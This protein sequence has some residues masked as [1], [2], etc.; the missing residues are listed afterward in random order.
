MRETAEAPGTAAAAGSGAAETGAEPGE[1]LEEQQLEQQREREGNPASPE[2][3]PGENKPPTAMKSVSRLPVPSTI[4]N[5]RMHSNENMPMM[6]KRLRISSPEPQQYRVPAS[7]ACTRPKPPAVSAVPKSYLTGRRSLAPVRTNSKAPAMV[8][9]ARQKPTQ[10][11][12]AAAKTE[13]SSTTSGTKKARAAWDLKGKVDDMRDQVSTYKSKLH[14]LAGENLHLRQTLEEIQGQLDVLKVENRELT[15]KCSSFNSELQVTQQKLTQMSEEA[16]ALR[17]VVSSQEGQL[18]SNLS[19][20]AELHDAK[21]HLVELA[22]SREVQ[23][24]LAHNELIVKRELVQSLQANVALLQDVGASKDERLHCLEMERRRLHNIIQELKGNIRVFCRVRPLLK[25]EINCNMDHIQFPP[26]DDRSVI[27]SK[28][29]ESHTG[30]EK[31]EAHKYDFTFDRVFSPSSCQG[32]VFHEISLLV[33]S[34]LDGYHVC[35]FAYGQTGS[36][37]TYTM[38]GPDDVDYETMGMIP[39]AVRQIFQ[40]ADE[41][42]SKGWNYTFTANFL[43]IY[44]E[45]IRD[46]L[47]SKPEKNVEYDIKRVSPSSDELQVTNLRYVGVSSEEEVHKLLRTAKLNRSVAKTVLNDRSS[48]SHSVFQLRIEGRNETRDVK[49]S[50]ILSL[51][52]L[53]GSERLDKSLSKG[54]RLRETQAINTSLSNLGLVITSLSN[55]DSHI[56]FR[57]SK[58]TY[59]LQNSLGGNSKVLMFVNVSP[60]DDNFSESVNSLR[61]ASKVNECVIGTAQANRKLRDAA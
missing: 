21:S 51:I 10:T 59:L 57:N 42:R 44:N 36:G 46:L 43:E 5:K 17:M 39:R 56:P 40:S 50:S 25:A 19:T 11:T 18:S 15:T 27:L 20:I 23:L 9:S 34:A 30:R 13:A 8:S 58:L 48:R 37:K 26:Q 16:A 60:L 12:S 54:E 22:D 38:E 52:D 61:F 49:T 53:A 24:K 4:R 45:A 14:S 29:E 35:I 2:M 31:K 32:E 47:V 6:E 1:K 28:S 55:K 33:Q 3:N 7:I 41:L